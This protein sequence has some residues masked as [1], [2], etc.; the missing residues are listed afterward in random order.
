MFSG[1]VVITGVLREN[2]GE[3]RELVFSFLVIRF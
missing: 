2:T 1:D 3:C